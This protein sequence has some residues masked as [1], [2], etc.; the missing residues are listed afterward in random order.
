MVDGTQKTIGAKRYLIDGISFAPD[1]FGAHAA[2]RNINPA[3]AMCSIH[4]IDCSEFEV[5]VTDGLRQ[6][7]RD[8]T[9]S[10]IGSNSQR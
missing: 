2:D 6:S 7:R 1:G 3:E 4:T 8:S 5:P 10:E 9:C